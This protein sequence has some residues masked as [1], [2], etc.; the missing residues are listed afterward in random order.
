MSKRLQIFQWLHVPPNAI[1]INDVCFINW[2]AQVEFLC[3]YDPDNA[4]SLKISLLDCQRITYDLLEPDY[5]ER[6]SIADVIGFHWH[7]QDANKHVVIHTD[8]WEMN[9]ICKDLAYEF[10]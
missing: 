5:A 8:L 2:G 10:R 4:R 6:E 1:L 3:I 9:V 7:D